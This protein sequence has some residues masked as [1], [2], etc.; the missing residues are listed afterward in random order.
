MIFPNLCSNLKICTGV[1]IL[2][3]GNYEMEIY[4]EG[5]L[6]KELESLSDSELLEL[7]SF[8]DLYLL[9]LNNLHNQ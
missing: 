3:S 1:N 4:F 5:L 7:I 2:Q 8:L 9:T 6:K